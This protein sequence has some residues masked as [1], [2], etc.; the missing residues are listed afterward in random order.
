MITTF[1]GNIT[2]LLLNCLILKDSTLASQTNVL[3]NSDSG[4]VLLNHLFMLIFKSKIGIVEL[5]TKTNIIYR[6]G[7]LVDIW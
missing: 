1:D 6:E 4:Y 5:I 3:K 7:K 2:L